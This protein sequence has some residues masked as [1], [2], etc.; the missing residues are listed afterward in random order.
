L[1]GLEFIP[2]N[3]SI[4]SYIPK[5]SVNTFSNIGI[6]IGGVDAAYYH[7][8]L[9]LLNRCD[10]LLGKK[11]DWIVPD[12]G[13][14]KELNNKNHS[15]KINLLDIQKDIF[16]FYLNCEL[17]IGACGVSLFERGYLNVPQIN[18]IVADN[19]YD[20]AESLLEKNLIAIAGHLK[21][22]SE[23]ILAAKMNHFFNSEMNLLTQK[24]ANFKKIISG[25]G[26]KNI[27]C[28]INSLEVFE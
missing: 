12:G 25:D 21:S 24:A 7:K 4:Q 19:Q 13:L 14:R 23:E 3:S 1:S 8:L 20:F 28:A 11:I 16:S 6:Y 2:L 5:T 27:V 26:V 22:D 15:L 10:F 17:F 18:F 9:I